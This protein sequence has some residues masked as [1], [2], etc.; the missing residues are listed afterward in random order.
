MVSTVD[1]IPTCDI[2]TN[3]RANG[4]VYRLIIQTC[5]RK[6]DGHLAVPVIYWHTNTKDRQTNV[7]MMSDIGPTNV[8][9]RQTDTHGQ[10]DTL[11]D[12]R[13]RLH[14]NELA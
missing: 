6:T 3:R 12:S 5:S 8:T 10:T 9:D 11:H 14:D 1:R 7:D 13:S 2:W 4:Q